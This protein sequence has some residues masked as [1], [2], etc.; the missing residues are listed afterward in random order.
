MRERSSANL[1]KSAES[2][3]EKQ[4]SEKETQQKLVKTI[5][6]V[7]T[8][9]SSKQVEALKKEVET[10]KSSRTAMQDAIFSYLEKKGGDTAALVK[11]L[12][13]MRG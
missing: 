2:K 3:S 4:K 9:S 13:Q 11:N 5:E 12:K 7:V 10:D 6:K 8:D 1:R